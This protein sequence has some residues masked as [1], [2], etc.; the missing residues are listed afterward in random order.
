MKAFPAVLCLASAFHRLRHPDGIFPHRPIVFV[1]PWGHLQFAE[2][3][4]AYPP[5]FPDFDDDSIF[6]IDFLDRQDFHVMSKAKNV[7]F[8]I[9]MAFIL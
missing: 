6:S 7:F 4:I 9:E 8:V 1:L 2:R 5:P 3:D